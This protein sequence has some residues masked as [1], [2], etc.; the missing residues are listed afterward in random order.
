MLSAPLQA[1][2]ECLIPDHRM[3][4]PFESAAALAEPWQMEQQH[5]CQVN[6]T[7]QHQAGKQAQQRLQQDRQQ[8]LQRLACL[9]EQQQQQHNPQAALLSQLCNAGA[10][11]SA[12]Q[13]LLRDPELCAMLSRCLSDPVATELLR[14]LLKA[15]SSWLQR[16]RSQE[17]HHHNQPTRPDL[18]IS[19][20]PQRPTKVQQD[21]TAPDTVPAQLPAV[22]PQT[23]GRPSGLMTQA[24]VMGP[25]HDL[26]PSGPTSRNSDEAIAP[27]SLNSNADD[28]A[29]C[30]SCSP[31]ISD[32]EAGLQPEVS[33]M[34]H[35]IV[36]QQAKP[37]AATDMQQWAD[38]DAV[39]VV[40]T[41]EAT[42]N[43]Q[44]RASNRVTGP[45]AVSGPSCQPSAAKRKRSGGWSSS[46]P[47][48][49]GA[50]SAV[51]LPAAVSSGAGQTF[52]I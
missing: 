50:S 19:E 4:S 22:L 46:L 49:A 33:V 34:L 37:E 26:A 18:G 39:H 12:L 14:G 17:L 7:V 9:R 6:T 47:P 30:T 25:P 11:Q 42:V 13:R 45:A 31:T 48:L 1:Q 24:A 28:T 51:A 44:S 27:V 15:S 2:V 35:E 10:L 3:Q 41:C 52:L 21:A 16:H 38:T 5:Q 36:S 32:G 29:G 43:E 40:A 23:M 20:P 8:Q